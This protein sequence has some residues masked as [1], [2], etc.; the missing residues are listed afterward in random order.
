MKLDTWGFLHRHGSG[1][2]L[3]FIRQELATPATPEDDFEF[4]EDSDGDGEVAIPTWGLTVEPTISREFDKESMAGGKRQ[5]DLAKQTRVPD[6][7]GGELS[8]TKAPRVAQQ[9]GGS[10]VGVTA[11]ELQAMLAAQ[12]AQL[13]ESQEAVVSK[14]AARFEAIVEERVGATETR[15]SQLEQKLEGLEAKL[16]KALE[17]GP[18]GGDSK[19]GDDAHR[20]QRTLIYGGWARDTRRGELLEELK[21]A[22]ESLGVAKYMDEAPFTTG[23]RRSIALS[24]FRERPGESYTDMRARMQF[25]IRAFYESEVIGKQGKKLWCSWSKSKQER[26]HSSHASLFKRIVGDIDRVKLLELD[27]EWAQGSV[28]T[29]SNMVASSAVPPPPGVD[30][31]GFVIRDH[32]DHKPWV[33]V[34]QAAVDLRIDEGALRRAYEE[35]HLERG[36]APPPTWR[37][38]RWFRDKERVEAAG[39]DGKADIFAKYASERG[40]AYRDPEEVK[41]AF[42]QEASSQEV[43]SLAIAAGWDVAFATAQQGDPHEAIH[44]HLTQVYKGAAPVAEDF[45]FDGEVQAFTMQEMRDALAL[46][47]SQKSVGSDYTSQELLVGVMTVPGGEDHML[48]WFNRILVKQVMPRAWNEPLVV[49]LPKVEGP[50][51]CK[52]LRPLAMGSSVGKLFARMLLTRTARHLAPRTSAQCAAPG[53]QTADFLFSIHRVF[54]LSREWGSPLCALKV[55]L[56]KAFDCVDRRKLLEKLRERMGS[57]AELGCWAGLMSDVTGVLQTPWGR[58]LSPMPSGIKQGAIESPSMFGFVAETVLEETRVANKWAEY[59]NLFEGLTEEECVYMDYGVLWSRGVQIMQEKVEAYARHLHLYGLSINLE[60]CQLYCSPRCTGSV[61]IN[62]EGAMLGP[63]QFLEVMGVQFKVEATTM[64]LITPLATKARNRF[65]EIRHILCSKGGL[66]KRIRTMQRTAAQAGLWCLSALPPDSGGLGYLN[67]VQIQLI[68]WMMRIRRGPSED[69]GAFRLRAWRAARAA[70]HRSGEERWSTTWLR[71]YWRFAGHRA[72]GLDREHP[73]LS[74]IIDSFRDKQ[75]WDSE[76]ADGNDEVP[77]AYTIPRQE[78]ASH[79]GSL[80]YQFPRAENATDSVGN[81]S[82]NYRNSHMEHVTTSGGQEADGDVQAGQWLNEVHLLEDWFVEGRATHLALAMVASRVGSDEAMEFRLWA[83]R[84]LR[85]LAMWGPGFAG[86]T[87]T[88]TTPPDF[89][90]W[91][92]R[93]ALLMRQHWLGN[94]LNLLQMGNGCPLAVGAGAR[95]TGPSDDPDDDVSSLVSG[96]GSPTGED[97]QT[98]LANENEAMRHRAQGW[99]RMAI[100]G[101]DEPP[102]GSGHAGPPVP[103]PV[104][105]PGREAE[106]SEGPGASPSVGARSRSR[107]RSRGTG[108]ARRTE[109]PEEEPASLLSLLQGLEVNESDTEGAV[110]MEMGTAAS[111]NRPDVDDDKPWWFGPCFTKARALLAKGVRAV[112]MKDCFLQELERLRDARFVNEMNNYVE[113]LLNFLREQ[114]VSNEESEGSTTDLESDGTTLQLW[115]VEAVD[116]LRFQWFQRLCPTALWNRRLEEDLRDMGLEDCRC[117]PERYVEEQREARDRRLSRSR[118]PQREFPVNRA[119]EAR[120]AIRAEITGEFGP[121]ETNRGRAQGLVR[122]DSRAP[123]GG[124]GRGVIEVDSSR[125]EEPSD[126]TGFMETNRGRD[127]DR[128][129]DDSRAPAWRRSGRGRDDDRGRGSD[130]SG[131]HP[132]WLENR[133]RSPGGAGARPEAAR[134]PPACVTRE[135]RRLQPSNRSYDS[136]GRRGSAG[137]G[138]HASGSGAASSDGRASAHTERLE[139]G[140][141][142]DVWRFLLGLDAESFEENIDV[143]AAGRPLLPEHV[144]AMVTETV[145]NYGAHDRAVMTVSFVRFLRLL[146]SEVMQAFERGVLADG[147]RARGEVLVE[148]PVDPL[149]GEG[150]GDGSSLMQRTL[151]GQFRSTPD[152]RQLWFQRV[153]RLQD[154]LGSQSGGCRNANI[155]GLQARLRQH[156]DIPVESRDS[157]VAMLVA[158]EDQDCRDG[159]VGDLAWQL[160]WWDCLFDNE[161]DARKPTVCANGTAL[162]SP[163]DADIQDM[164][165]EEEPIRRE[166]EREEEARVRQQA[167]HEKE[168]DELLQYQLSLLEGR[169][170]TNG[171]DGLHGDR[172]CGSNDPPLARLSAAEYRQWEDWEWHNLLREPPL[173][174]KRSVTQ[175]TVSGTNG[176]SSPSVIRSLTVPMASS[177]TM[178]LKL[179][180]HMKVE[181][182]PDDVE[183]IILDRSEKALGSEELAAEA[184]G[185]VPV[186]G[187]LEV[188]DQPAAER[189]PV[190]DQETVPSELGEGQPGLEHAAEDTQKLEDTVESNEPEQPPAEQVD[191][192]GAATRHGMSQLEWRDYEDLYNRWKAGGLSD[193]EVKGVGG[194]NLLDLME[195]QFIL[196]IDGTSSEQGPKANQESQE[197]KN[198]K[199]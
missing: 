48:E 76:T 75:W 39:R 5:I 64:E 193:D 95:G 31:A 136:T 40:T 81:G 82:P 134:S 51:K 35:V 58:S 170:R 43:G 185:A 194:T 32:L 85:W 106:E 96:S 126:E 128:G 8:P 114:A 7:D 186:S 66:S 30:T 111:V 56:N 49:L 92:D 22:T 149:P 159:G 13:V 190:D 144:S 156:P 173:K 130:L 62:L 80:D 138:A 189:H 63:S 132:R 125:G 116:R 12:T 150:E 142:V 154:E 177:G 16:N 124:R 99:K 151:T 52:Q 199:S 6:D 164:A 187:A 50:T 15:V 118:T 120:T 171:E 174:R 91:A 179:D 94:E 182:Y 129:R 167:D 74:S 198:E 110:F 140:Q 168:E 89:A 61:A 196:D 158:M 47:K 44:Q 10:G 23:V 87:S 180:F 72:R 135:V 2:H 25:I 113:E 68:V 176:H 14:A 70:L 33:N 165:L 122:D 26:V 24:S 97:S 143:V 101:E 102:A 169:G 148:V 191:L 28:W 36:V 108:S 93:M 103:L 78:N 105:E 139:E 127:R 109:G 145:A 163:G 175:V 183:T 83:R 90:A 53:R 157:L 38:R 4:E 161:E 178:S 153:R 84:W 27:V 172:A 162:D 160:K 18:V 147:A 67:S 86:E 41:K 29:H 19:S 71:R 115:A 104:N 88:E 188:L 152:P 11:A 20:R 166:K 141:G 131:V 181:Q 65:W 21:K 100:E 146:M 59:P 45:R 79:D 3:E 1:Q 55:D 133:T 155:A 112:R 107:S 73:A 54:E 37:A 121:L 98:L 192:L 57:C 77:V 60:K 17:S 46:L 197:V 34:R 123:A 42:R 69:W 184:V 9:G 137:S 119:Q 117:P 195:A